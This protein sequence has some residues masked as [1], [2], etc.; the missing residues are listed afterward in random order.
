M[1]ILVRCQAFHMYATIFNPYDTTRLIPISTFYRSGWGNVNNLST[2]TQPTNG[3]RGIWTQDWL[4]LKTTILH[5]LLHVSSSLDKKFIPS[6]E[7]QGLRQSAV[8]LLKLSLITQVNMHLLVL[9]DYPP[10]PVMPEQILTH[11]PSCPL[12]FCFLGC[13]LSVLLYLSHPLIFTFVEAKQ[14][15]LALR[16]GFK[17]WDVITLVLITP[18]F[19]QPSGS[20]F[21]SILWVL[22]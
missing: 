22:L 20:A 9:F 21:S 17:F 10:I 1:C 18:T 8:F 4:A 12:G 5:N 3:G 2:V 11:D 6:W 16:I 13:F 7:N 19:F 15:N 14:P